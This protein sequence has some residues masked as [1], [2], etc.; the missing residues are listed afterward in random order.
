MRLGHNP[1]RPARTRVAA[2]SKTMHSPIYLRHCTNPGAVIPRPVSPGLV[3]VSGASHLGFCTRIG[4]RPAMTLDL[5]SRRTPSLSR[6]SLVPIPAISSSASRSGDGRHLGQRKERSSSSC[7]IDGRPTRLPWACTGRPVQPDTDALPLCRGVRRT[8]AIGRSCPVRH[9]Q[10]DRAAPGPSYRAL[11]TPL[12][13]RLTATA[14]STRPVISGTVL[15]IR[16]A[17]TAR[18]IL[19]TLA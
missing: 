11:R 19:T 5:C 13:A 15:R 14:E 6:A 1:P 17:K 16:E 12:A 7:S 18:H 2:G 8:S 9:I 3:Q 4:A 10:A